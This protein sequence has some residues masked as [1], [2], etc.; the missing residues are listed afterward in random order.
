MVENID[1]DAYFTADMTPL[2]DVEQYE[3]REIDVLTR[4]VVSHFEQYVKLNKKVPPEILTSLAGIEQ[5]GRLADTVAAHM[6]L[7]LSEKQKVLESAGRARAPRAGDVPDRGR[8]GGAADREEDPRPREVA[9]G[10]EPARVLPQRAD[11]GDPEGAR[12]PRGRAER[13]RRPRKAHR[14]GRHAEGGAREGDRRAQQ[15]EA[16]VA[17]VGRGHGG[18]QLRRLAGQDAVEEAHQGAPRHR[19]R[20]AGARRGPLRP[21]EGQGAHRRVP[22]RHAA[23]EAAQGPDPVP[24]RPARRRQDLARPVDRARDEPQVRAHV[25]RRRARRGRD[26]RPPPHLHR[27]AAGQG[28]AEH[29]A[30]RR[31]EPAVPVRRSRQDVDGFPRRPVV[32]AARG[33]RPRAEHLVLRP[34]PRGR[35]RPV[36][37]HVRVHGEHAQHSRRRCSTAWK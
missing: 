6:A 33:A 23:R 35:L 30:H 20:A 10:E 27:L 19:G 8:D 31:Q 15:A 3:E 29:G 28:A 17:D 1:V 9:D 37:G 7:K 18:P 12:R 5:P 22:R 11:E 2:P 36:R 16:D 24:R 14:Q 25:A 34:L 21:R 26:P 32:G 4:S 13:A